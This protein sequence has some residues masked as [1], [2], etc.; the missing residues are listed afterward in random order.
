MYILVQQYHK[1][2]ENII[3][4]WLR[5]RMNFYIHKNHY[6][7]FMYINVGTNW[8]PLK[9]SECFIIYFLPIIYFINTSRH[10]PVH[11]QER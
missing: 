5:M 4:V 10:G 7:V 6:W 11:F 2:E 8:E 1:T 9:K 3:H